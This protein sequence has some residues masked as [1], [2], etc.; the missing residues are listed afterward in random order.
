MKKLLVSVLILGSISFMGCGN[1]PDAKKY[2]EDNTPNIQEQ[3]DWWSIAEEYNPHK[4]YTKGDVVYYEGE[5]D[6]T[7]DALS[8][9]DEYWIGFKNW[10]ESN[11]FSMREYKD[12]L[13]WG[14]KIRV[15]G[16]SGASDCFWIKDFEIIEAYG[17]TLNDYIRERTWMDKNGIS[18]EEAKQLMKWCNENEEC[19]VFE[20]AL[21]DQSVYDLYPELNN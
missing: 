7:W 17:I 18:K 2:V 12:A 4:E 15:V 8:D 16:E 3:V 13:P 6:S 11:D 14:G 20:E 5:I 21:G 10:Y 1:N 19:K 9:T